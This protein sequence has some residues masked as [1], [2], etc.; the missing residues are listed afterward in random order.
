[1]D[2][3]LYYLIGCL[4][5]FGVTHTFTIPYKEGGK[6]SDFNLYIYGTL[7]LTVIVFLIGVF[8][9]FVRRFGGDAD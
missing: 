2:I 8:V 5:G 3:V 6:M 4:V 9:G 1:V 7:S